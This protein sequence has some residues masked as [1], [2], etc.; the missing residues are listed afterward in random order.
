MSAFY[1]MDIAALPGFPVRIVYE[2]HPGETTTTTVLSM[3]AK[4]IAD[5]VFDI[6][7]D[8][9]PLSLPLPTSPTPA[10]DGAKAASQ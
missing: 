2:L 5:S 4:P 8:Y 6:P 1:G 7:A 3:D 10:P 9:K